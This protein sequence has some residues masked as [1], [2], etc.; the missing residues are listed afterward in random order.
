M[1]NRAGDATRWVGCAMMRDGFELWALLLR[2]WK[3]APILTNV[4]RN[5]T[6]FLWCFCIV[7]YCQVEKLTG[8]LDTA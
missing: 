8:W 5:E 3:C 2:W 4:E 1:K 6:L 7:S